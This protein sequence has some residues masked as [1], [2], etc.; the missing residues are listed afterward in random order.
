M[1]W[2]SSVVSEEV[3]KQWKTGTA[4]TFEPDAA[5]TTVSI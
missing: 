4:L 3:D 1:A 2:R 5:F